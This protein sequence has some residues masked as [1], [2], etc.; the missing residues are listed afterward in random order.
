VSD[1]VR[2]GLV[3]GGI[4]ALVIAFAWRFVVI[5]GRRRQ[6]R[7]ALEAPD[8][9]DRA[10]AGIVLVDEGLQRSARPLLAHLASESDPRVCHAIALAIARRQWE[11]VDTLRVR[12]LREWASQ[13]LQ[14]R[15]EPVQSFGP[16]VTRLSD[17]GGPRSPDSEAQVAEDQE[18]ARHAAGA[19]GTDP[20]PPAVHWQAEA[21][22]S[23]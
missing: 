2:I 11:P 7:R 9:Q 10:R 15:G 22:E 19:G 20:V 18:H 16:A 23:R 6:L 8:P 21:P 4:A 5:H 13:E 3:V 14:R 12:Q 1:N 17:M